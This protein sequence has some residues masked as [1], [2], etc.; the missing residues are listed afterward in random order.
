M[1]I[2][3]REVRSFLLKENLIFNGDMPS[4]EAAGVAEFLYWIL[5]RDDEDKVHYTSSSD[6]AGIA[7]CLTRMSFEILN[8]I[9]FGPIPITETPCSLIYSPAPLY[10]ANG[11]ENSGQRMKIPRDLSTLVSI[12]QP[13]ETFSTFPITIKNII[14]LTGNFE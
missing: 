7:L 1:S 5:C 12:T 14:R 10:S 13:Q 8:V 4:E 2:E 3:C 11:I 6:I 9:D